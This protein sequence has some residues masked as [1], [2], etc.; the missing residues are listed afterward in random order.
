MPKKP[1]APV[2]LVPYGSPSATAILPTFGLK[3]LLCPHC[4]DGAQRIMRAS[5]FWRD[6]SDVLCPQIHV[7]IDFLC[8]GCEQG[9]QLKLFNEDEGEGEVIIDITAVET[10]VAEDQKLG[11]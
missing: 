5:Q 9:W 10:V 2:R 4:G 7:E 11:L 3:D 1:T 8:R 6:A